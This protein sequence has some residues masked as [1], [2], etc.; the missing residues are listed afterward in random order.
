MPSVG[1]TIKSEFGTGKVVS[2]DILKRKYKIDVDG[3]IREI[4]LGDV[5]CSK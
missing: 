5:S 3:V 2:V 4:E 1:Q